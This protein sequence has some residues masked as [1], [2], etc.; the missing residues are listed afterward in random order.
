MSKDRLLLVPDDGCGSHS[1]QPIFGTLAGTHQQILQ[2]VPIVDVTSLSDGESNYHYSLI[3]YLTIAFIT[4]NDKYTIK[5]FC[6][7]KKVPIKEI[8]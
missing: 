7:Y 3:H 5:Y 2:V 4:N 1:M 6:T 8:D